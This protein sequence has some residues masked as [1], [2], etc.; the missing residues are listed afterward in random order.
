MLELT[1]DFIIKS[2]NGE[3]IGNYNPIVK[4]II[5]D[6]R[7]DVDDNTLFI[8]LKGENHDGHK[9]VKE[10]L[11]KG[12]SV[13]IVSNIEDIDIKELNGKVLILVDDTL[14]AL[15]KIAKSYRSL[16]NLPLV[17][18]TGSVGKTTTKEILYRCLNSSYDTLYTKGNYNNDIG[19]PLTI[20]NLEKNHEVGVVEVAMRG[21]GE[22]SRLVDIA[23]PTCAIIT[24]VELVHLESLGSLENIVKAKCEVLETLGSEDFALINGDNDLLLEMTSRYPVRKYTFGYKDNC[25]CKVINISSNDKGM[26]IFMQIFAEKISLNFPIPAPKLALNVVAGVSMAYML[27]VP[28]PEIIK[29]IE[30]Y[31]P[32]D[33]RLK[34]NYLPTGGIII[35][36][37]Y[38]ANPV[39]MQ[40]AIET[41]RL[42]KGNNRFVA[43]L[44]DMLELGEYEEEGHR[45]VGRYVATNQV[46]ILITVGSRAKYIAEGAIAAGMDQT[47]IY[48]FF[49][50]TEC[51]TF[52]HH[53]LNYTDIILFKASRGLELETLIEGWLG[54]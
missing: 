38:N 16:F 23:R 22:I 46:D 49:D 8:A 26:Q 6:S 33:N 9:F 18:I 1:L 39:S 35:N 29:Q 52:L 19:L 15:Q 36:D 31:E 7:Q 2:C 51:L 47:R 41:S 21:L 17:A 40:A 44:G 25:D 14:L 4:Q 27:G 53:N 32:A 11:E 50:K 13:A 10:V 34:I 30:T 12:A 28:I 20:L 45:E 42:L 54:G 43:V 5:T 48:H 37:T 3:K 24:N